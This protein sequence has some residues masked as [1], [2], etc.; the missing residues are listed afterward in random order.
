MLAALQAADEAHYVMSASIDG[1]ARRGEHKRTD[2]LVEGHAY[3]LL[4][5]Y[6]DHGVQLLQLR[7]PWGD[8]CEW[9]GDWSDRSPLWEAVR[10]CHHP[11]R[12][13]SAIR[14]GETLA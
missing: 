13:P 4:A 1:G 12:R 6:K 7:N 8:D 5:V 9:N 3:T 11:N 10:Y 14:T 2:G